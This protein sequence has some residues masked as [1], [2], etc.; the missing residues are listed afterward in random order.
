MKIKSLIAM[1]MAAVA[2][3]VGMSSC[4]SDDDEPEV[5]LSAQVV[6]SYTGPEVITIMGE[7]EEDNATFVFSQSSETTIDMTIPQSG[8]GMMVI[9]PLT[10]KNIP[11]SKVNQSIMGRLSSFAGT[12]TNA[13]GAEKAF[14]VSDVTVIFEDVPN[15]KAVVASFTLKYG[16]MPFDMVT[17]FTGNKN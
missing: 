15:G 4:S 14:T 13:S 2:I 10:V 1:M 17:T 3:V 16:S 5:A 9:P 11:L 7:P 12:V 8:E 6:G